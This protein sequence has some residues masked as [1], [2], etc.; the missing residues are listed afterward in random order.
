MKTLGWRWRCWRGW[1]VFTVWRWNWSWNQ[2]W[3]RSWI[4]PESLNL[5]LTLN[6]VYFK[7][8]LCKALT[9]E[10]LSDHMRTV[11][12]N[13]HHVNCWSEPFL[14]SLWRQSVLPQATSWNL[15]LVLLVLIQTW[16]RSDPPRPPRQTP[17][18]GRAGPADLRAAFLDFNWLEMMNDSTS[19]CRAERRRP[20]RFTS[21]P[22][23]LV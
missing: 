20:D 1:A 9:A 11:E 15:S 12:M 10:H 13:Q 22:D 7:S 2:S 14:I 8:R 18:T 3:R 23:R 17:R 19:Q 5:I 4:L 16:F 21:G 6:P